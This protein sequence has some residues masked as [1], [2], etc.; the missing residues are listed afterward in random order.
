[1]RSRA[2]TQRKLPP[3]P[4]RNA[5]DFR[6][7]EPLHEPGKIVVEPSLKHGPQ[8]LAGVFVQQARIVEHPAGHERLKLRGDRGRGVGGD[9]RRSER[10]VSAS[11]KRSAS[12]GSSATN[13]S[14]CSMSLLRHE[15]LIARGELRLGVRSALRSAASAG[16]VTRSLHSRA[17]GIARASSCTADLNVS[18]GLSRPSFAGT[19]PAPSPRGRRSMTA[20][21]GPAGACAPR[22]KGKR[23]RA[24]PHPPR[25]VDGWRRESPPWT[26]RS[27]GD[28]RSRNEVAAVRS[29]MSSGLRAL[30][31][32]PTNRRRPF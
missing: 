9:E 8:H 19:A 26:V 10:R 12:C 5:L 18:L 15:R 17:G 6:P 22:P 30:R 16:I 27:F 11:M 13:T 7:H 21:F 28:L 31:R 23:R 25:S 4:A 3:P 14:S 24:R 32:L 1:M 2:K 29:R 20:R